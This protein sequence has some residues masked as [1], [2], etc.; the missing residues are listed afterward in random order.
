MLYSRGE[1]F[2]ANADGGNTLRLTY[3]TASLE[4]I[5]RGVAILGELI[6]GLRPERPEL[7]RR[8]VESVPIL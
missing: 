3:S 7:V 5:E 1:L 8:P 4:E 2:H 6:R